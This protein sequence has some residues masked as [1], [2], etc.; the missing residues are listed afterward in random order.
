MFIRWA[1]SPV[2]SCAEGPEAVTGTILGTPCDD[3]IVAPPGVEAVKGA[4]GDD[5]IVAAP[6]GASAPCPDGCHLGVGSQTF[7]AAGD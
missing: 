1:E 3:L 4:G 7:E 5:T 2:P 6:I